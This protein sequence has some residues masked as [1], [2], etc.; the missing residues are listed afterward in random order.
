MV[1]PID[2]PKRIARS[3]APLFSTGSVPGNAMSTT[4]ACVFGAAPNA[5]GA[6]EKI[7]DC[8]DNCACVSNPMTTS[9]LIR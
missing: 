4:L 7:F 2:S 9:Q 6:P 1:A 3:T 8:V 5:V